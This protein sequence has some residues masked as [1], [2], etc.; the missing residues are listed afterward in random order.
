[1]RGKQLGIF[2]ENGIVRAKEFIADKITAKELCLEEV[3]IN[4][5]QLKML[6]EKSQI[7]STNSQINFNDQNSNTETIIET[8]A[9]TPEQSPGPSPTLEPTPTPE[10]PIPSPTPDVGDTES[11]ILDL[12]AESNDSGQI[13]TTPE[14]TPEATQEL[15][16]IT[17]ELVQE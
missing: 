13:G 11:S 3:C 17:E 9:P 4:K 2:F 14:S 5:E 10:L 6:L 1:M 7:P 8:P 16:P 15:T 12:P